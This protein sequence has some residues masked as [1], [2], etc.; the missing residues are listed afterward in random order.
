M[1]LNLTFVEKMPWAQKLVILIGIIAL[2]GGVWY[3]FMYLPVVEEMAKVQREKEKESDNLKELK[4]RKA[5]LQNMKKG[6]EE[7]EDRFREK[8]E[9]LPID[10]EIDQIILKLDNLGKK[11][12]IEFSRITPHNP[13]AVGNLYRQVPI[14]LEFT[15]NFR[16]VMRFYYEVVNMKRIVEI[17]D[18]SMRPHGKGGARISVNC[19]AT[20]Y[21]SF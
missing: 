8:R 3:Y 4:Q 2:L 14:K 13:S 20:T 16:Y 11:N 15:G 6:I 7:L 10:P 9:A 1:A 19:N 17:S 21:I 5:D 18:I 12:G